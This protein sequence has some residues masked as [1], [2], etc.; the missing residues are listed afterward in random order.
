MLRENKPRSPSKVE[1]YDRS[2]AV[3]IRGFTESDSTVPP[4]RFQNDLHQFTE[5]VNTVFKNS[6]EI[7]V[8][9]AYRMGSTYCNK[10]G[11]QRPGPLKV[12]LESTEQAQKLID[13]KCIR[14]PQFFF[15]KD[16]HPTERQKMR[17]LRTELSLRRQKGEKHLTIKDGKIVT[18]TRP[19]LWRTAVT[20][21]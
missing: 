5:T 15:Q 7:Q 3:I 14:A 8:R 18:T 17:D 12:I 2:K 9:K 21:T 13:T 4:E 6:H 1:T 20:I 16:F 19:F 11:E 10:D